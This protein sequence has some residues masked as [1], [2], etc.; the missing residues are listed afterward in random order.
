MA[1]LYGIKPDEERPYVPKIC[2][3]EDEADQPVFLLKFLTV[4]EHSDIQDELFSSSG[5]GKKRQEKFLLGKQ[6]WLTLRTGL[7]G[8][9]NFKHEDGTAV[10]WEDPSAGRDV[11]DKNRIMDKNLNK[12]QPDI[13]AEMAEYIRGESTLGEAE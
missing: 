12:I 7:R 5:F 10:E 13:R 2:R 4:R 1:K 3:D 6:T 9:Q 8:W 11:E